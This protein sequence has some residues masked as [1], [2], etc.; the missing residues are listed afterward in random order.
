MTNALSQRTLKLI[1]SPRPKPEDIDYFGGCP[2]CWR[3]NGYLNVG[4][5]HW[6]VCHEHRVK[7]LAGENLFS[8]WRDE[9]NIDWQGN[10]ARIARYREVAPVRP[11]AS[12]AS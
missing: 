3:N 1:R 12:A 4:P 6:F 7:W 5:Q 2:R 10:A 11:P 9:S 8:T